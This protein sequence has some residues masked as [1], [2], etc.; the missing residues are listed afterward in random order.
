VLDDYRQ[1]KAF[2]D[3]NGDTQRTRQQ[4]VKESLGNLYKDYLTPVGDDGRAKRLENLF[5]VV[6]SGKKPD[7]LKKHASR[8]KRAYEAEKEH[9]ENI[10]AQM[11]DG[12][13]GD[14]NEQKRLRQLEKSMKYYGECLDK[15][16]Q[17]GRLNVKEKKLEG[18]LD[19]FGK[20]QT[21]RWSF[22]G[23]NKKGADDAAKSDDK[24][25][26]RGGKQ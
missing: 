8:L 26:P 16:E 6:S 7:A 24:P 9:Y 17:H 25:K 4:M 18:V 11:P 14:E 2:Y 20:R 22:F 23:G 19:T 13:W 21:S 10:M 12:T 5:K 1:G 15:L 3:L